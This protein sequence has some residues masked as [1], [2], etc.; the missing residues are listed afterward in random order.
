MVLTMM[1]VVAQF[2]FQ[3]II[4]SPKDRIL[5]QNAGVG[6]RGVVYMRDRQSCVDIRSRRVIVFLLGP[7]VGCAVVLPR[8]MADGFA[9]PAAARFLGMVGAVGALPVRSG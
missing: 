6:V 7:A 1:I 2:S 8:Y 5:N 9:R 3:H 4:F